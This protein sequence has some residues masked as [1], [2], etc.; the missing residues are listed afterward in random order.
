M[1]LHLACLLFM[2]SSPALAEP[3]WPPITESILQQAD[4]LNPGHKAETELKKLPKQFRS[5]ASMTPQDI[6][7][8]IQVKGADDPLDVTIWLNTEKIVSERPYGEIFLRAAIDKKSKDVMYQIYIILRSHRGSF[9]PSRLTMEAPDGAKEVEVKEVDFSPSCSGSSCIIYE[10]AVATIDREDL[11][12]AARAEAPP[13]QVLW[14]MKIFGDTVEGQELGIFRVEVAGFLRAVDNVL[15]KLSPP[16]SPAP[17][18][19]SAPA[20]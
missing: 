5:L 16:A 17:A 1:K 9:N 10:D 6:A 15:L 14:R 11:D 8:Q 19:P 12:F 20:T 2:V 18:I 7:N 3:K 4:R 13:E